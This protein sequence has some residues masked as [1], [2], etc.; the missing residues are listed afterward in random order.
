MHG[1]LTGSD[2]PIRYG[3]MPV[4]Q[5]EHALALEKVRYHGEPV[6]A[7]AAIDEETAEEEALRLI[8]VEYEELASVSSIEDAMKPGTCR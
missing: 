6:V 5:D 2:L 3:I 7:V 1:V 8:K 4:A